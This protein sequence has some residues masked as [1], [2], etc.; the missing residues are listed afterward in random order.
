[1]ACSDTPGSLTGARFKT[2]GPRG[3]MEDHV[4]TEKGLT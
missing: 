1:M 4:I 2:W 3:L